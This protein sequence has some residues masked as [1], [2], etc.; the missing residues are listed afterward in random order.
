[1]ICKAYT[2]YFVPITTHWGAES[3]S[4]GFLSSLLGSGCECYGYDVRIVGH[5]L[6]GAIAALLGIKVRPSLVGRYT[7]VYVL[8]GM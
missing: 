6:G 8:F 4:S 7:V 2:N 3:E 5:S 1:M